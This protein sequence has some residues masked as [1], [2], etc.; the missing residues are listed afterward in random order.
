ST[1]VVCT[2]KFMASRAR[3]LSRRL[4]LQ[5]LDLLA[6]LLCLG[7]VR[8]EPD[9]LPVGLERD[10]VVARLEGRVGEQ[11]LEQDVVWR[12]RGDLQIELGRACVRALEARVELRQL[13]VGG[14]R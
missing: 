8:C 10:R 3:S 7:A 12:V 5:I 4:T 2:S 11:E 6:G 14:G 9:H 1:R 13:L